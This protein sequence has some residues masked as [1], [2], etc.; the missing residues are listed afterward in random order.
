VNAGAGA[1][2]HD[3][4]AVTKGAVGDSAPGTNV[5]VRPYGVDCD[6]FMANY[7]PRVKH[8][9]SASKQMAECKKRKREKD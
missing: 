1:V 7:D 6:E 8:S 9:R 3:G 5:E 2:D 4:L